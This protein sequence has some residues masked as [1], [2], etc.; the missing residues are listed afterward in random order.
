MPFE[1]KRKSQKKKKYNAPM[2]SA[3]KRNER[4]YAILRTEMDK[5][6]QAKKLSRLAVHNQENTYAKEDVR[7]A[8]GLSEKGRAIRKSIGELCRCNPFR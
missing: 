4:N 5:E 2:R 3:K 1:K 6:K 8:N 7:D